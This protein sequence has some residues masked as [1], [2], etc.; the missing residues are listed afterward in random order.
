M[1]KVNDR[2]RAAAKRLYGTPGVERDGA[3]VPTWAGVSVLPDGAY[4]EMQVWVPA[5]EAAKEAGDGDK[6]S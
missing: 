4:V 1:S 3:S 6:E 2:Y 5:A